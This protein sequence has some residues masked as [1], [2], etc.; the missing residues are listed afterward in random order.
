MGRARIHE[1]PGELT[2]NS[3][4][5][6]A[7]LDIHKEFIH[8]A[9]VDEGYQVVASHLDETIQAKIIKGE[10][11]DFGWLIPKD[12][13]QAQEEYRV[14]MKIKDGKTVWS[15]SS[16]EEITQISNYPRWEQAF[17]IFS[18]VYLRAHPERAVELIQYNHIIHMASQSYIWENVY[19][20]D[21]DFR[22]HLACNPT[23]LWSIIL[24]QAWSFRLKD[25]LR[26]DRN[27]FNSSNHSGGSGAYKNDRREIC[28]K[29][30]R[31][32]C[33][34]GFSCKFDHRCSYCFKFSH[35]AQ[36]CRRFSSDKN[37]RYDNHRRGSSPDKRRE[38]RIKERECERK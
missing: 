17:R 19:M 37:D 36:N 33:S 38:G 34:Y 12:R 1:T 27:L 13:V 23:R 3:Q 7:N 21:R 32:R 5:A 4:L 2:K 26:L 11:I 9:M 22:L 24:Q 18:D 8:S 14:E 10:Y 16:A 20:Y 25:R 29:F 31:G 30:N 35:G 15:T 6:Q 28:R